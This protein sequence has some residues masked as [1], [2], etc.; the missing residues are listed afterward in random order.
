MKRKSPAVE[1]AK[2]PAALRKR[3]ASSRKPP[4]AA[5][6]YWSRKTVSVRSCGSTLAASSRT[7]SNAST[8]GRWPATGPVDGEML[9][10]ALLEEEAGTALR[11]PP[12]GDG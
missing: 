11:Q 2:S 12:M 5:A 7:S 9:A 6:S 8:V 10:V 3:R 1:N 4:Y